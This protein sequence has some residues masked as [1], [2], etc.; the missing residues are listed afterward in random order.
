[1]GV[2][3]ACSTL[4][5]LAPVKLVV[6]FTTGGLISGYCEIG[7][8]C[9]ASNPSITMM[10]LITIATIGLLTKNSPITFLDI[11]LVSEG[12][13]IDTPGCQFVILGF[14]TDP[15]FNCCVPPKAILSPTFNPSA[16]M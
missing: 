16:T 7:V 3:T 13:S 5:A 2:A 8:F 6:I 10:I 12:F 11:Y 1:M 15:F 14:I 4:S 9:N